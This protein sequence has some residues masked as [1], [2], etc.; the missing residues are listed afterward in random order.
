MFNFIFKK[1]S[2]SVNKRKTNKLKTKKNLSRFRIDGPNAFN[3]PYEELSPKGDLAQSRSINGKLE[4]KWL[5]NVSTN[6]AIKSH[7]PE[8]LDDCSGS[9]LHVVKESNQA[10]VNGFWSRWRSLRRRKPSTTS[11]K[12]SQTRTNAQIGKYNQK[13]SSHNSNVSS[14]KNSN[15]PFSQCIENNSPGNLTT[16]PSLATSS[17]CQSSQ[18]QVLKQ[19]ILNYKNVGKVFN[20][21]A[22]T[23]KKDTVTESKVVSTQTEIHTAFVYGCVMYHSLLPLLKL[24]VL[25]HTTE[26]NKKFKMVKLM[27]NGLPKKLNTQIFNFASE[28]EMLREAVQNFYSSSAET[29]KP[30]KF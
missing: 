1:K 9:V 5:E 30:I 6:G 16:E 8:D 7:L 18:K 24:P 13:S 22:S 14:N 12:K 17:F 19:L 11:S 3:T 10:K 23:L 25:H 28:F 27:I 15:K 29:S 21:P 4:V 2:N 20:K 26:T